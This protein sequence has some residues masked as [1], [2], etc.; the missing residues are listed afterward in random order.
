MAET[1]TSAADTG[2]RGR[3]S[4]TPVEAPAQRDEM[5]DPAEA[6][7]GYERSPEDLLRLVVSTGVLFAVLTATALLTLGFFFFNGPV[8]ELETQLIQEGMQ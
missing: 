4:P 5:F 7:A 8:I 3:P 2:T 6:V 1:T